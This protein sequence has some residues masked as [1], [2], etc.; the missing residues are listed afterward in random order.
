M[1]KK[2][3][4]A[5]AMAFAMAAG[6]LAAAAPVGAVR[7]AD[8]DTTTG[9]EVVKVEGKIDYTNY[10]LTITPKTGDNYVF[11]EVLKKKAD[12]KPGTIYPYPCKDGAVT[13][14]L[15]FLKAA[16]PSYIKIWGDKNTERVSMT[17]S[18]QPAKSKFKYTPQEAPVKGADEADD[19]FAEKLL[20][21]Y[22][23]SFGITGTGNYE[24]KPLYGYAWN[25]LGKLD[26]ATAKVAGTTLVMRE[27]A[28]ESEAAAGDKPA[29]VGAP[30]GAE[31]KVKVSAM[32]K[33]PKVTIDYTKDTV[34]LPKKA[35]YGII[36]ANGDLKYVDCAAGGA[37]APSK[38]LEEVGKAAGL[39][40]TESSK[41][42]T[43]YVKAG[44]EDDFT[45]VVRTK[46]DRKNGVSL[47]A[48]VTVKAHPTF[49][50]NESGKLLGGTDG[51]TEIATYKFDDAGATLTFSAGGFEYKNSGRNG[52]KWVKVTSGKA[53]KGKT[54][55][56]LRIAGV[57][58]KDEKKCSLPSV[59][60][61]TIAKDMTA[62]EI[63]NTGDLKVEAN[64]TLALTVKV[65]DKKG[66][67]VAS[68]ALT[69]TSSDETKATVAN[70]TVSGVAAGNVTITVSYTAGEGDKAVTVTDKV[71]IE[72]T[73]AP[74]A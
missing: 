62:V 65:T 6:L 70:G 3:F 28:V 57:K 46:D 18:G 56:T 13:I 15:S 44:I 68:P 69:W 40:D 16:K 19:A 38:I 36:D 26:L 27:A 60:E 33:A 21:Y 67:T 24:F 20:K 71:E 45:L 34:K 58:D 10:T 11:L 30:A 39:K 63:T 9:T 59:T 61:V 48:F 49:T 43:E 12:T 7:A 64:K 42:L 35:Q 22:K 1:L 72:V 29:V 73:A 2:K 66:E 8:G 41:A 4:F 32:P 74:A 23:D 47:P 31:V 53:I 17:V 50:D 37:I 51:T 14:D 5:K 25:Y 54:S 55:L 52:E